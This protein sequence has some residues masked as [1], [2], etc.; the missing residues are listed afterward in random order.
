MATAIDIRQLAARLEAEVAAHGC[1]SPSCDM[2]RDVVEY[3]AVRL[4]PANTQTRPVVTETPEERAR[5]AQ[6]AQDA[7]FGA[8]LPC[9]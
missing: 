3:L 9:Y 2:C 7:V 4:P 8:T 5:A 1:Q 6:L